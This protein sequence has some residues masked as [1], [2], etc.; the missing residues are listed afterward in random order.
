VVV[1]FAAGHARTNRA[2]CAEDAAGDG[3]KAAMSIRKF[4]D[5]KRD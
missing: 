2:K 5:K 1:V 4:L 3:Y